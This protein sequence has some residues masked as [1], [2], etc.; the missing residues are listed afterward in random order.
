VF[1][2]FL[3]AN[4]DIYAW[5]P[6]DMPSMPREIVEHSLKVDVKAKPIK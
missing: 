1:V 4:S 5:K 2:K 3:R 6:A